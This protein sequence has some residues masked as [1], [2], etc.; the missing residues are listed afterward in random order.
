MEL[1]VIHFVKKAFMEL[2]QCVGNTALR[3][4]LTLES[5]VSSHHLTEEVLD[6]PVNQ[7][8]SM[9]IKISQRDARSGGS[10]GTQN[11]MMVSITLDVVS[12]HQTAQ[13]I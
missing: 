3:G 1:Y 8:V 13:A 12:A 2:G 9:I 11:A 10:S 7:S 5:I 4:T 6:T